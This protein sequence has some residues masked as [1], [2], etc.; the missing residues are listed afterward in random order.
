MLEEQIPTY[1]VG[2]KVCV[3]VRIK[4]GSTEG[5]FRRIAARFVHEADTTSEIELSDDPAGLSE[6]QVQRPGKVELAGRV[7]SGVHPPGVYRCKT[8]IAEY[9]VGG[10]VRFSNIPNARFRVTA[11]SPEVVEWQWLGQTTTNAS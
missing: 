5:G 8:M 1:S 7:L 9:V 10:T 11:R 6:C 2:D 3:A 4:A